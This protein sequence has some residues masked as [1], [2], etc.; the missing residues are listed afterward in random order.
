MNLEKVK[1]LYR[2]QAYT[3]RYNTSIIQPKSMHCKE[4]VIIG[5]I[6]CLAA[7]E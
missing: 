2:R 5:T 4:Y 1:Y 6:T 3:Y 7:D